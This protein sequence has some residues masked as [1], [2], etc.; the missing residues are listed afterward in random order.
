MPLAV[1][2]PLS[3]DLSVFTHDSHAPE[4]VVRVRGVCAVCPHFTTVWCV[5]EE[6]R[7]LRNPSSTAFEV[8]VQVTDSS[9]EDGRSWLVFLEVSFLTW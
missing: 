2:T 6:G 7:C 9:V 8:S 5:P 1:Q 4:W 3:W